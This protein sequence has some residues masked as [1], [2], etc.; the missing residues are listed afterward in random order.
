MVT[1]MPTEKELLEI[2]V[3]SLS[4]AGID[5]KIQVH[6][7]A[8]ITEGYFVVFFKD[9]GTIGLYHID[10]IKGNGEPSRVSIVNGEYKEVG[11]NGTALISYRIGPGAAKDELTDKNIEDGV[12]RVE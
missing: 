4:R 1:Q 9:R 10:E 11:P 7:L 5:S 8:D 2:R 3:A 6:N 12:F